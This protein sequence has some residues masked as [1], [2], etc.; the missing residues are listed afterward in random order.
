ME[1]LKEMIKKIKLNNKII[2]SIALIIMIISTIILIKLYKNK[3]SLI[4]DC[5]KNN[6]EEA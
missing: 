1:V 6:Q 2:I 4:I 5:E 3:E